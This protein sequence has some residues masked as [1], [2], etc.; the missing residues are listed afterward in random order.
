MTAMTMG[1]KELC[2]RYSAKAASGGDNSF[3][4]RSSSQSY[5]SGDHG[6]L[7]SSM[8]KDMSEPISAGRQ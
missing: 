1:M 4:F 7:K 5:E 6:I 8:A 3:S 2:A